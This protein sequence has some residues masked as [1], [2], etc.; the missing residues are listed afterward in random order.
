MTLDCTCKERAVKGHFFFV[1]RILRQFE[2]FNGKSPQKIKKIAKDIDRRG[3]IWYD[4]IEPICD[5]FKNIFI[6]EE[7]RY[8]D[9][10]C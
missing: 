1:L 5:G 4:N 7:E 6:I 2:K 9:Q 8:E 3:K 10:S